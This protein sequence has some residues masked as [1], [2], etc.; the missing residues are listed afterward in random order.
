[1]Q[2]N[3]VN[4]E[5]CSAFMSSEGRCL[6]QAH[7]ALDSAACVV[8]VAVIC[9]P[10]SSVLRLSLPPSL[11]PYLF[12]LTFQCDGCPVP[13]A[14]GL[15]AGWRGFSSHRAK[16]YLGVG[17]AITESPISCRE[18]SPFKSRPLAVFASTL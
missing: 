10:S 15:M 14:L 8:F 5:E 1:M 6:A 18:I 4:N 3:A 2:F 9:P 17:C 7:L 16:F 13:L 11:S 12:T